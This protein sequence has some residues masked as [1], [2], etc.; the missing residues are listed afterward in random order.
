MKT[1]ALVGSLLVAMLSTMS[2]VHA[3]ATK[4]V[5]SA[6]S[7][8]L[9]TSSTSVSIRSVEA[10]G[11]VS[12][13]NWP[14]KL[15]AFPEGRP[16]LQVTIRVP[17]GSN[18]KLPANAAWNPTTGE[19]KL[20]MVRA[21]AQIIRPNDTILVSLESNG[22]LVYLSESCKSQNLSFRQSK[23]ARLLPLFLHFNC[24]SAGKESAEVTVSY[25]S[26]QMAF[27]GNTGTSATTTAS[28]ASARFMVSTASNPKESGPRRVAGFKLTDAKLMANSAAYEVYFNPV[29]G[30]RWFFDGGLGL[31]FLAYDEPTQTPPVT[32]SMIGLTGKFG[33][34][35]KLKPDKWD[36]VIS[37]YSTL[38]PIPISRDPSTTPASWYAGGNLRAGYR[39]PETTKIFNSKLRLYGGWYAWTM[40]G[41]DIYGVSLLSGPQFFAI[42]DQPTWKNGNTSFSYLKYS[43]IA[44]SV[45]DLELGNFEVAIGG[46]YNF[47]WGTRKFTA[48]LDIARISAETSDAQN[49]FSLLS[50]SA[51]LGMPIGGE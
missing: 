14:A 28:P 22:P 43:P 41:Q 1:P 16:E 10:D 27:T 39:F 4:S 51:G 46:G 3:Q 11:T 8:N 47:K 2:S 13:L 23:D 42:L 21:D 31:S 18:Q 12:E 19:L 44:S 5:F 6:L 32:I 50:C 25:P 29:G 35:Y 33:A 9:S 17:K 15:T 40:T 36:I 30:K 37:G 45:S 48:T 26:G 24:R 20:K 7:E 38:V 49:K 34:L